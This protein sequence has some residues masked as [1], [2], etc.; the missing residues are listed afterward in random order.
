MSHQ[1]GGTFDPV[2]IGEG[3]YTMSA[4]LERL[5]AGRSLEGVLSVMFRQGPKSIKNPPRP[6]IEDLDALPMPARGLP[7]DARR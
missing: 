2:V 4:T 1:R 7:G 6:L 3:K 5:E